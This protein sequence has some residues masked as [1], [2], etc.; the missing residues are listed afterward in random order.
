MDGARE[1]TSGA[2][3][4]GGQALE[5]HSLLERGLIRPQKRLK[6]QQVFTC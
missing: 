6:G 1:A 4:F 3:G 5:G 2:S